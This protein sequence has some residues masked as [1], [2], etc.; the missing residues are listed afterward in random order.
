MV[1]ASIATPTWYLW[2]ATIF[3]TLGFD[4]VYA[5][6]DRDDDL[7]IGVNSSAI[8]FGKYVAEAI[9]IFYAL[10]VGLLGYMGQIMGL[11]SIFVL[12]LGMSAGCWLWQ[13]LRLKRSTIP[14]AFYPQ[15]FRENVWIG[16]GL[17]LGMILGI[18][19]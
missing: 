5:M 4:T 9:A 17:L 10:T 15:M 16:F 19:H 13:Y 11:G 8:F 2:G 6:S 3:W 12:T 7:R 1:T 18:R 14:P